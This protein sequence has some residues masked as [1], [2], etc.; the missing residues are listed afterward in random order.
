MKNKTFILVLILI[1]AITFGATLLVLQVQQKASSGLQTETIAVDP[2]SSTIT[3]SGTIH[4]QNEATLHFQTA[5]K[6]IYLPF[7]EGDHITRGQT[8][9]QLDT[10][11]LQ[12][13]L[14]LAA[15][16]YQ[17][18][19]NSTDQTQENN[20]AGIVEGQQRA[21]LDKSTTNSYNNITESQV[22]TDT[23]RRYVD[24]S[25]LTQNSAQL[26]VDIANYAL[27]LAT[28]TAPFNGVITREDVTVTNQN[29]TPATS[30][31]VAD[32]TNLVFKANVLATDI[33]FVSVGS[34]ATI[35]I[36][37]QNQTIQGTVTKI[38][39]DKT[40]LSD[41]EQT[42]QVDIQSSAM[43]TQAKLGQTGSVSIQSNTNANVILVPAW[44]VLSHNYLWV[45]E[46]GKSVLKHVSAGKIHGEEIEI[47]GGLA[48][49]DKIIVK[50]EGIARQ[51]YQLL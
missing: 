1:F 34:P 6:L 28:L 20:Q 51:D 25:L 39:P 31:A 15:N 16:A 22:V 45:S 4:S 43:N 37:G 35:Q 24:N 40:T 42:Y 3:A 38:Y 50:P 32:P 21:A 10:Y 9:A 11:A 49:G 41:G 27:Q 18:A 44:T 14:Q 33:D 5:G 29:I 26:S 17:I 46:N 19:K 23:V 8:V 47:T 48:P 36:D 13:D 12:K 7:K 2:V 30:F